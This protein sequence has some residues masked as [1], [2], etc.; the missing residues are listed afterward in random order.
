MARPRGRP[1]LIP[2]P[3]EL[4]AVEHYVSIG[5]TQEQVAQLL[6]RSIPWLKKRC[7]RELENGALRVNAM[8]A[9]KLYE[10]CMRGDTTAIIF[11]CKVRLGWKESQIAELVGKDGSS[12]TDWWKVNGLPASVETTSLPA[13]AVA[14]TPVLE[15]EY[16]PELD[17]L[18]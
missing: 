9:G 10:R 5:Y 17:E 7:K 16:D 13:T 1:S 15:Q 2:T 3:E 8:V 18:G 14:P 11:W 4:R 12:L 6:G